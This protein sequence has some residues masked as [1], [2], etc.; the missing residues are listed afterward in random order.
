VTGETYLI[1]SNVHRMWWAPN[2]TGYTQILAHAGAYSRADAL[3]ICH[4]AITGTADRIGKL[5]DLPIR[6]ADLLHMLRDEDGAEYV[7][8]TESWE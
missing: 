6:R 1:W 8:G 3:L 5:P 2:S 7:P 4:Q